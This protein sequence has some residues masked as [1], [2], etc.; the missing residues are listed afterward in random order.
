MGDKITG[1]FSLEIQ[2]IGME[3]DPNHTEEFAYEMYATDKYIANV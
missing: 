3:F 1:P 2:Y